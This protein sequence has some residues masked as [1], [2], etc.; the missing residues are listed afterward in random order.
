MAETPKGEQPD[1]A[2]STFREKARL[3]VQT[4]LGAGTDIKKAILEKDFKTM[5]VAN[6]AWAK[7][8]PNHPLAKAIT[9][10]NSKSDAEAVESLKKVQDKLG[11]AKEKQDGVIWQN[12]LLE[13]TRIAENTD[14]KN[15][16]DEA[17]KLLQNLE[18]GGKTAGKKTTGL[19]WEFPIE[20][21]N[22][23]KAITNQENKVIMDKY[24]T[25][26]NTW[27]TQLWE[28]PFDKSALY[29]TDDNKIRNEQ[30]EIY[31]P[32]LGKFETIVKEEKKVDV[33]EVNKSED[34]IIALWKNTKI[35]EKDV[36]GMKISEIVDIDLAKIRNPEL[37]RQIIS[38]QNA[39]RWDWVSE[40]IRGLTIKQYSDYKN[41]PL[42]AASRLTPNGKWKLPW[43]LGEKNVLYKKW[44]TKSDNLDLIDHI[45]FMYR[46]ENAPTVITY[47][48]NPNKPKEVAL[49]ERFKK[50][51]TYTLPDQ[52]ILKVVTSP[53]DGKMK[54]FV[55][56]NENE[57]TS[58]QWASN[59]DWKLEKVT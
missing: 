53:T 24:V 2:D 48:T 3:Q 34:P 51:G 40:A 54:W 39:L 9:A 19:I 7:E 30:W 29:V 43:W 17:L 32:T 13:F 28:N 11:I 18:M 57:M 16:A 26:V 25:E 33:K 44:K 31:N 12:S 50:L 55:Y 4:T 36:W 49:S 35:G 22:R 46:W 37:G 23:E 8:Y 59:S 41:D 15:D 14:K 20:R 56:K 38:A 42:L 58:P 1:Y 10:L 45:T 6:K 21:L 27:A 5:M 47:D 52:S